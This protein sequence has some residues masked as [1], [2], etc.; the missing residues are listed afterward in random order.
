MECPL[1]RDLTRTMN[2][3]N[4]SYQHGTQSKTSLNHSLANDVLVISCTCVLV[5][6]HSFSSF[7]H[8]LIGTDTQ[9]LDTQAS[10][11][12]GEP[13]KNLKK[14]R[15]NIFEVV[16]CTDNFIK[17]PMSVVLKTFVEGVGYAGDVVKIPPMQARLD[18]LLPGIAEYPTP[19]ALEWARQY[20]ANT[21]IKR[22]SSLFSPR[23]IRLLRETLFS[24]DMNASTRW[25][26]EP[27][28]VRTALRCAGLVVPEEAITLPEEPIEGPDN[29]LGKDVV[30]QIMINGKDEAR[31]RLRIQSAEAK[32]FTVSP[33]DD[34]GTPWFME[35]PVAYLDAQK[36]E[37]AEL[38]E[39]TVDAYERE[40]LE[41]REKGIG[42]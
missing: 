37:I 33:L 39:I 13:H 14:R 36:E 32:S 6:F 15:M 31:C 21:D 28:H 16:E 3:H 38:H 2:D 12:N 29:A 9:C 5:T 24:L 26:L 34:S 4:L 8:A 27:W 41:L 40:L 42:I 11:Q 35:E 10:S 1:L 30:V 22:H 17:E 19:E 7:D 25:R 18:F 20:Q 23:I